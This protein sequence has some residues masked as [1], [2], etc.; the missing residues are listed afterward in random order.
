VSP[1]GRKFRTRSRR[2][3]V[4]AIAAVCA[5][6]VAGTCVIEATAKSTF[7][8]RK[9]QAGA[10]ATHP[11]ACK[12]RKKSRAGRRKPQGRVTPR[13]CVRPRRPSGTSRPPLHAPVVKPPVAKPPVQ[14]P[15][16]KPPV[17]K[18]PVV[19]PPVVKPPV[20]KPPVVQ[21]PVVQ[22]PVTQPP[23]PGGAP[24]LFAPDSFWNAPLDSA[25]PLDGSSPVRMSAFVS[26]VRSEI[27]QGIGP[28]IS[29]SEYSTPLYTVGPSQPRVRIKLDTGSWG[30]PLRTAL[31]EGVPIPTNARQAK[32]TDGHMTIYQPSTDTL[33]EFWQ[34]NRQADGWHASWGGAMRNVSTSPGYYTSSS[35]PGLASSDG[36]NWGST[37]S[38]LP[39]IGGTITIADLKSG[40]ID[41]ALA[42]DIPAPCAG[43]FTWPAQRTDGTSKS[44]DCLPEGARLRLDP[45]LDLS[46]L[47]LPPF[48]RMLA[49]AAQR[50]G[51]VVRDKTGHATG[52]YAEDPTP[53]GA[54]PYWGPD[55]FYGGLKPWNFLPPFPWDKLRLLRMSTCVAAPCSRPG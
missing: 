3:V 9:L 48:T 55:G 35:W 54:E 52:F 24:R 19:Q 13:R 43:T 46:K 30:D 38:S 50:Y 11:G 8:A 22:P 6:A 2:A 18:P 5:V 41:H 44:P 12:K 36:W 45:A 16:V 23:P 49:E 15:V 39:I 28:W 34:A 7:I 14:P 4:A 37:A 17:V 47:D 31:A 21:P 10:G 26:Q 29:E 32:G 1:S 20:V 27:K 53:T 33:W 51:M 40:H 42:L 25:A